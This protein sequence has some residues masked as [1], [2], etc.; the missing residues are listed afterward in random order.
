M[1]EDKKRYIEYLESQL[2]DLEKQR[3]INEINYYLVNYTVI[4]KDSCSL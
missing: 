4:G 3:K 1:E 2:I